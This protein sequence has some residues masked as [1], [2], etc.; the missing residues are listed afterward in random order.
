MSV[1]LK[2]NLKPSTEKKIILSKRGRDMT[3]LSSL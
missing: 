1:K 2:E 3:D